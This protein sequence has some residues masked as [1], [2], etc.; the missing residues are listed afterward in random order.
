MKFKIVMLASIGLAVSCQKSEPETTPKKEEIK[1]EQ[2]TPKEEPSDPTEEENP[3]VTDRKELFIRKIF[4]SVLRGETSVDVSEFNLS[5]VNKVSGMDYLYAQNEEFKMWFDEFKIRYPF[6]LHLNYIGEYSRTIKPE[7][8]NEVKTYNLEYIAKVNL[9]QTYKEVEK[10]LEKYY[11]GLHSEMTETDIAYSIY[12]Q[13]VKEV[14]YVQEQYSFQ[15]T[16]ALVNKKAV[17]EGYSLAYRLLMNLLGIETQMVIS[18]VL[19]EGVAHAWNRVKIDGQWYNV[20]ATWDDT[21]KVLPFTLGDYFLTSD[22]MF[23][24][25]KNHPK[26]LHYYQIPEA[27]STRFDNADIAFFRNNR[28]QTDAVFYGG[29][30]YYLDKQSREVKR[31]KIGEKPQILHTISQKL[32]KSEIR[33]ALGS[34]RIYFTDYDSSKNRYAVRSIDYQGNNLKVEKHI[35][36][37]EPIKVSLK[38]ENDTPKRSFSGAVA[39]RTE[40]GLAKLQDAYYHGE[41]DYFKAENPKRKELLRTIK[42]AENLLKQNPNNHSQ[43]QD[44]YQKIKD[45]RKNY[46]MAFSVKK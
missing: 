17:C 1:T 3:K 29:Y 40:I 41:E 43:A 28:N 6:L 24:G 42:Q 45:L 15:A 44:L 46:T 27:N 35:T 25:M 10:A 14:S 30:W 5:E 39:L 21:P 11:S 4:N 31:T 23:H 19:P 34:E 33:L 12:N 32:H 2:P 26:A 8:P 7:N 18:G 20:D 38:A 36:P 22:A 16:G 13:L 9:E 37:E